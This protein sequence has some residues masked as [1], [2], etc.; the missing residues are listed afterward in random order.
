MSRMIPK[1]FLS[2]PLS[3]LS[4]LALSVS[5]CFS[6]GTAYGLPV[7]PNVVSGTASIS[8]IGKVLNVV[9]SD[10]AIINWQTFGIGRDETV[11]F[12]QPS[13]SSMV[14]NRVL[15][16]DPSR[17]LGGMTSNGKV[18][19]VNPAGILVGPN[20]RI[21]TAGFVASTLPVSNADFLANKLVFGNEAHRNGS[22][23]NDGVIRTPEG[24]SVY[25]IG[26]N[27]ANNGLIEAPGGETLLAAGQKIQLI[28][29][30]TPGVK[31]EVTGRSGDV[32]NI[33]SILADAGRIGLVGAAVKVGGLLN[34][35][36]SNVVNDGGRIFLKASQ[37]IKIDSAGRINADGASGGAISVDALGTVQVSGQLT[38][39]G[40]QGLGGSV[41][42]LGANVG[43]NG[44]ARVDVSGVSGGGSVR[45][46][47]DFQG[48][49]AAVRNAQFTY[50][51]SGASIVADGVNEGNGGR[52]ILWADDTARVYGSISAQG[53][54]RGGNGGFVET[55]GKR[56]LD[57]IA[58]VSV[59]AHA[60]DAG[61]LLLDPENIL[62]ATGGGSVPEILDPSFT[63]MF[64][65]FASNTASISPAAL[66]AIGGNVVLQASEDIV[67]ASPVALT[68]PGAGL[69]ATA[70]ETLYVVHG[71]DITTNGGAV[72]LHAG[73]VGFADGD[74]DIPLFGAGSCTDGCYISH[75]LNVMADIRT[76]GGAISLVTDNG[77]IL[78]G[79]STLIAPTLASGG[80]MLSLVSSDD[81]EIRSST[82]SS[83]GG[84]LQAIASGGLYSYASSV[85][86]AGGVITLTA[87]SQGVYADEDSI[88]ESGNGNVTINAP[89]S[90]ISLGDC[91]Y[92]C[93][94]GGVGHF[95]TGTGTTSLNA[96]Y[97]ISLGAHSGTGAVSAISTFSDVDIFTKSGNLVIG[98]ISSGSDVVLYADV[99]SIE[100]SGPSSLISAVSEIDLNALSGHVGTPAQSIN[101]D[102]PY[103]YA[104]V[105]AGLNLDVAAG[106]T[107]NELG[108]YLSAAGLGT[109]S[110]VTG[111][112]NL[113]TIS[114][115]SNGSTITYSQVAVSPLN[116]L[117]LDS[118]GGALV[119][120]T[121]SGVNS[122]YLY[123]DGGLTLGS[124]T[125]AGGGTVNLNESGGDITVGTFSGSGTNFYAYSVSGKIDIGNATG[126]SYVNLNAQQ[127]VTVGSVA[128][129]SFNLYANSYAGKVSIA[130]AS[131]VSYVSLSGDTGLDVGTLSGTGYSFY[132]DGGNGSV[133][134]TSASGVGYTNLWANGGIDVGVI[135]GS[136]Q[137][138]LSTN[139]A[140]QA[141]T[142][143]DAGYEITTTGSVTLDAGG[144]I[145]SPASAGHPFDVMGS[146]IYLT[147]GGAIGGAGSPVVATSTGQLYVDAGGLFD[148]ENRVDPGT[149]QAYN[150]VRISTS[151]AAIGTGTST[152]ASTNYSGNSLTLTG[153]SGA[154]VTISGLASFTGSQEFGFRDAANLSLGN[155]SSLGSQLRVGTGG[156]LTAGTINV[157]SGN[158]YLDAY[159]AM[160]TGDLTSS[161]TYLNDDYGTGGGTVNVGSIN[162]TWYLYA[163]GGDFA[164]TSL[165]AYNVYVNSAGSIVVGGG[166]GTVDA[167]QGMTFQTGNGSIATGNISSIGRIS[168]SASNGN[169]DTGDLTGTTSLSRVVQL[170]ASGDGV[171]TGNIHVGVVTATP[172][173][174][175][176]YL[177]SFNASGSVTLASLSSASVPGGSAYGVSISSGKPFTDANVTDGAT[178][179]KTGILN[180]YA[181]S[182]SGI[183]AIDLTSATTTTATTVSLNGGDGDILADISGATILD[184]STGGV[185]HV[186]TTASLGNLSI[187]GHSAGIGAS[188]VSSPGRTINL[189]GGAVDDLLVS[190]V[191]SGGAMG[192]TMNVSESPV[193]F[194]VALGS[195]I[196]N[197]G[198]VN[199]S[200]YD[201]RLSATSLDSAGGQVALYAGNG[202]LD[203]NGLLSGNG[204]VDLEAYGNV[205][206]TGVSAGNGSVY[207]WANGDL[208]VNTLSGN[209]VHLESNGA[210]LSVDS[211]TSLWNLEMQVMSGALNVGNVSSSGPMALHAGSN[212][213]LNGTLSSMVYGLDA[214]SDTGSILGTAG[215]AISVG[216][217]P[218][219]LS[220]ANGS[221]G[222]AAT[223]LN[224]QVTSNLSQL[225]VMAADE[226]AVDVKNGAALANLSQLQLAVNGSGS[227]LVSVN[228][229]NLPVGLVTRSAGDLLVAGTAATTGGLTQLGIAN[230]TG[231]LT[232]TGNLGAVG[233]TLQ[234]V[235]LGAHGNTVIHGDI[236]VATGGSIWLGGGVDKNTSGAITPNNA[237]D[238][239]I[240]AS[241]GPR[242]ISTVNGSLS[243]Y[244]GRDLVIQG[245]AGAGESV[246]ITSSSGNFNAY[247]F[248]DLK[249]LGGGT[250]S[251]VT[252]NTRNQGYYAGH[253][254][255]V[256]SGAATGAGITLESGIYAQTFNG[257]TSFNYPGYGSL[258]PDSLTFQ[259]QNGAVLVHGGAQNFWSAGS[260]TI[261]VLGGGVGGTVTLSGSSQ[262]FDS[263]ND[264]IFTSGVDT[265]ATVSLTSSGG[266]NFYADG[267]G[268]AHGIL[269]TAQA[270][271]VSLTASSSQN[272]Y[273]YGDIEFKGGTATGASALVSGSS[274]TLQTN[275]GG[276][277][278]VGGSGANA[279]ARVSA[280]GSQTI[281][282]YASS[283]G[284]MSLLAGSGAGSSAQL[285]A[286]GSQ[287]VVL[288]G[289]DLILS[290]GSGGGGSARMQAG[291]SQNLNVYSGSVLLTGGAGGGSSAELIAGSSQYLYVNQGNVA[292][293]GG[294]GTSSANDD[295]RI[296]ANGYQYVTA[297]NVVLTGGTDYSDVTI[298]NATG[299]QNIYAENVTLQT[300][301]GANS[302]TRTAIEN[303]GSG[304]QMIHIG[305][306]S[307]DSERGESLFTGG[308]LALTNNHSAG[309][310]LI[311]SGGSQKLDA[312]AISVTVGA[313]NT[314][315]SAVSGITSGSDQIISSVYSPDGPG[316]L[317]SAAGSGTAKITSS[318][319][320]E[321]SIIDISTL[322][323]RGQIV[324]GTSSGNGR[325]EI[326]SGAD[327]EILTGSLTISGGAGSGARSKIT[328]AG[329]QAISTLAGGLFLAGGS[330]ANASAEIDP[331][332]QSIL[333]N[334][335]VSLA[336]GAG[337]GAVAAITGGTLALLA[338]GDLSLG[339]G[340]QLTSTNPGLVG[341]VAQLS[342]LGNISSTIAISQVGINLDAVVPEGS[343]P[344][345]EV[346]NEVISNMGDAVDPEAPSLVL[347][348]G[349]AGGAVIDDGGTT[350]GG[351]A[352][353]FGSSE[354]SEEEGK[355][356]KA[357]GSEGEKVK[358]E[359]KPAGRKPA[360]C[361]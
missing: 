219:K 3:R 30:G 148:I 204:H 213:T 104:D 209:G 296:V 186:S 220:A 275:N 278:V 280:T 286:G 97:D 223:P 273:T 300:S 143:N 301:A 32:T 329:T 16:A 271:A 194:G 236:Q 142:D 2:S 245:G 26:A 48:K 193:G 188:T 96:K 183:A 255:L 187:S 25:L 340:S 165:T 218:V 91:G 128:G 18:W 319:Y 49:N 134:V 33:G 6:A 22:V 294:V 156:N 42:I 268:P 361:S 225:N 21:D 348:T 325:S 79:H 164:A 358:K 45:V 206:A 75:S 246:S 83:G 336:N 72:T 215:H 114:I 263:T 251:A 118:D 69:T 242:T 155:A 269:V 101:V 304:A 227:G 326:T 357:D 57:F 131:G 20:A 162:T 47:G 153:S 248:N 28:D 208:T 124:F 138:Y 274:Q 95:T 126:L 38:A 184:L 354:Q 356:D 102:A 145:G 308:Y 264:L 235:T 178:G 310:V 120:T 344:V 34:A 17:L 1:A 67:F 152:L 195:T 108:L 71:A 122:A 305:A 299:S 163:Y 202:N 160:V 315:T 345:P 197:G 36:A 89:N 314:A 283:N 189:S 90:S 247:A 342:N 171:T 55:S 237:G 191:S 82:L 192:L 287:Y 343:L 232:L 107:V 332:V 221:V 140:I 70:G 330:G 50:F 351:D 303:L 297:K 136:G 261:S 347:E 54:S 234:N 115:S 316:L 98:T 15:A 105:A 100:A 266:Q 200:A 224:I 359:D 333:A 87:A 259:A 309:D 147:A 352:G 137:V 86:S 141:I 167:S 253:D 250:G 51:G 37:D 144:S 159:G 341:Y 76:L 154:N 121:L 181:Y 327:Q 355:K 203:V 349:S 94:G 346:L 211:V 103:I 29:T 182:P 46:G 207:V 106:R 217:A 68:A 238:L 252:I 324:L 119:V 77:G 130:D 222:S 317:V 262:Y 93:Y 4:P 282:S 60:G 179:L 318:G 150:S 267:Y 168:L 284:G 205:T 127:D 279:Y 243:L 110:T 64:G 239:V 265:T 335:D 313:A 112:A 306:Y 14:L 291:T 133:R 174:S 27:V 151:A 59:G 135:S 339:A 196:T 228:T 9:N 323:A 56:N 35:S 19:L 39:S 62:I 307:Y 360:A 212:V 321:L 293:T 257:S 146:N 53:G 298:R 117:Y 132:G 129:A 43:L 74:S 185:F 7:A 302:N 233:T 312:G 337:S 73:T 66:A 109:A 40:A 288:Y 166:S 198:A 173:V 52:V 230:R 10:K 81:I 92:Y 229:A 254:I 8:Q 190:A 180:V 285:L 201:G 199:I 113:G 5:M 116:R 78:V 111:G 292:L 272:F 13:S 270:A 241:G 65:A 290:A 214:A 281:Y 125:S 169:I 311:S 11:R 322:E 177:N 216:T 176:S 63:D 338:N 244:G 256:K 320:Q 331:T 161:Y 172:T 80:G 12:I 226:V 84:A 260:G 328:A 31:V 277:H 85:L 334:G 175:S 99:G 23:V 158:L 44:F 258:A 170:Y 149:L 350:T 249:I 88:L 276:I 231:G 58:S 41:D 61:T 139:G 24:G 240:E 123:A 289:N 210:T 157:G 295:S 353:T